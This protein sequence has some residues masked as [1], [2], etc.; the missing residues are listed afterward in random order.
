MI[1]Y[2]TVAGI[3]RYVAVP[4]RVLRNAVISDDM[5]GSDILDHVEMWVMNNQIAYFEFFEDATDAEFDAELEDRR[6]VFE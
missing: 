2:A 1:F 4:E 6:L 5:D 3:R